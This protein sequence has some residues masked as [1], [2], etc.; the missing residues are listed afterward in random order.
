[1]SDKKTFKYMYSLIKR[2]LDDETVKFEVV[3]KDGFKWGDSSSPKGALFDALAVGI[4]LK[5]IEIGMFVPDFGEVLQR[6]NG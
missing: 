6:A 1:M 5:D 4:N 2:V 3:G